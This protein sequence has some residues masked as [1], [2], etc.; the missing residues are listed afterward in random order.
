MN[1]ISEL[2]TTAED[3]RADIILLSETWLNEGSNTAFLQI[4]DYDLM[5]DLRSDRTDTASGIGGGLLV[6]AKKGLT[7]LTCDKDYQF[8]QY[9]K[10]A[11]DSETGRQFFYL[12]YRPPGYNR[13]GLEQLGNFLENAEPNSHFFGD[14]NLP[15]VDWEEGTANRR[16]EDLLR[17]VE[18]GQFQQMVQF[19]THIKGTVT[20]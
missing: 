18:E 3:L 15:G 11:I 20:D 1:K 2:K 8:N 14:F 4:D 5:T 19:T 10:F 12:I 16:E 17:V 9:V 7:V 6:Y 13:E